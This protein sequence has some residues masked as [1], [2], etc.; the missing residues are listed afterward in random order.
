MSAGAV[1]IVG[2]RRGTGMPQ[3]GVRQLQRLPLRGSLSWAL[4]IHIQAR[5]KVSGQ[6]T[7]PTGRPVNADLSVQKRAGS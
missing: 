4:S 5:S 1:W 7:L 6:A 3:L 2:A